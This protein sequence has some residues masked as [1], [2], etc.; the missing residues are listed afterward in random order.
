MFPLQTYRS[1]K[2]ILTIRQNMKL[3]GLQKSQFPNSLVNWEKTWKHSLG[4]R[5]NNPILQIT[6]SSSWIGKTWE[7]HLEQHLKIRKSFQIWKNLLFK[8]I[9]VIYI[10]QGGSHLKHNEWDIPLQTSEN[11][12]NLSINLEKW[13]FESIV[14][15]AHPAEFLALEKHSY[16]PL[17]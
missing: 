15:F 7:V 9:L 4:L 17:I 11:C 5:S 12:R 8:I 14:N 10:K 13:N 3:S 6:Q 2:T 16:Y 1:R